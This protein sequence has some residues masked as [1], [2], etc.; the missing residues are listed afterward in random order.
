MFVVVYHKITVPDEFWKITHNEI[1]KLPKNIRLHA[2]WP[3]NDM[4][5][6]TCL[7]EGENITSINDYLDNTLGEVSYH[8]FQIVNEKFAM[9]LP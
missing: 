9:G 6:S 2:V 3:S 1:T 4:K 5:L 7:W 8:D